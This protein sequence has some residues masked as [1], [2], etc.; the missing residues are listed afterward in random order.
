MKKARILIVDDEYLIRWNLKKKLEKWGYIPFEASTGK[1]A[2]EETQRINPNLVILDLILPDLKG[3]DVLKEIKKINPNISVIVITAYGTIEDAVFSIK[4]GA[5]DFITKPINYEV[6][7]N[8]V[9]NSLEAHFLKEEIIFYKEKEKEEALTDKIVGDSFRIKEA[10]DLALKVARSEASTVL[11]LGESGTGKELFA[12]FIHYNS[13]R[14]YGPFIPINCSTLPENLLESELFGYEKGAFTDAKA[15][16][17]GLFEVA[18]GGT[19][20]LDEIGDMKPAL[21]VKLLRVLEDNYFRRI[22]GIHEIYVDV[23]VIAASNHELEKDVEK[24][25]FRKDLFYRL[26]LF[27]IKLPPLRERKEDILPLANHFI[28]ILNQKLKKNIKSIETNAKK[29]LLEYDW[30]GNVRELKNAVERAMILEDDSILHSENLPIKIKEKNELNPDILFEIPE[31]GASLENIE[32]SLIIKALQKSK[33]NQKKAAELLSIGR[34]AIR[35][36]I[37]KYKINVK[38]FKSSHITH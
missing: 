29:I 34:D 16:K 35:Y 2:I 13:K 37:K 21:Q 4:E 23:R 25:D 17:K 3:T 36:K 9:K 20:F 38:D 10:L 14:S 24:G 8:L 1:S 15:Q 5:F 26:N 19:I 30:P 27:P 31:C 28:N 33:G 6:L 22:G 32:K 7:E 12:K 11:L 18:D